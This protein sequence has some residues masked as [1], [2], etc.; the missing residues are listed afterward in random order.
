M[1]RVPFW[2]I[3]GPE[4]EVTTGDVVRDFG[5]FYKTF[6]EKLDGDAAID[7]LNQGV[8][9]PDRKYD[10][11]SATGLFIRAYTSYYK[12]YCTGKGMRDRIENLVTQSIQNPEVQRRGVNWARTKIKEGLADKEAH[13]NNM[14]NQ[15]FFIDV[16]PDNAER[17]TLRHSDVLEK[18]RP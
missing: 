18:I 2:A 11:L 1:E 10:F 12:S 7:A 4:F 14:K 17:F 9:S 13:F 3:I 8:A 6:F 5:A 16:F 15:F